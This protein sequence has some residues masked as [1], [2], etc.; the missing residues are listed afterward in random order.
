M[1]IGRRAIVTG[2]SRGIGLALSQKLAQLG[3]SITMVARNED[4][5]YENMN[6]LDKS[7]DQKH[8]YVSFDLM[9]F[10]REKPLE[11][12]GCDLLKE[13]LQEATYLVNCAG[14]A[15][16]SL[17]AKTPNDVIANVIGLN[18]IAPTVLSK[19]A[20][21]P[22][23]KLSRKTKVVPSILNVSSMLS[24]TGLTV[25]GTSAYAASKAGLLGLT[26][27]LAA[28][29]N[30]KV[31]V[32]AALPLLVRETD[33]GK[34]ASAD[35]PTVPLETVTEACANIL[36]DEK[37]NGKFVPVDGSGFRCLN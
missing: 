23:M 24:T 35:M 33:M 5:L 25:P 4:L 32:N 22:M 26:E 12:D 20:L 16:Y 19:M 7:H 1:L 8:R 36:M 37:L 6:H 29:L 9:D 34:G 11:A 13:N 10:A 17:L 21:A 14:V 28:E 18:L 2:A 27:S 30:G 15:T 3:C 31:R